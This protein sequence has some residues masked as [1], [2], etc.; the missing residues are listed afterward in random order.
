MKFWKVTCYKNSKNSLQA[1]KIVT[2]RTQSLFPIADSCMC[3]LYFVFLLFST[4]NPDEKTT[5]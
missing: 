2:I 3:Y 1:I 4:N 5:L